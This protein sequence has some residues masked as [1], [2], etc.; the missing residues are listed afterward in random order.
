MR[1]S[2]F[3][4]IRSLVYERSRI[5]LGSDKRELVSARLGKRLRATN[6]ATVGE[7][8]LLLKSP[9]AEQ[10][11]ANLIDVISTNHT[12]FFREG[13][14]FDFLRSRAVPEMRERARAERWPQFNVWSAASSSGEETYSIAMT[15]SS[16]LT[17]WAW[18]IEGTDISHRIL[19][20]AQAAIYR[21]ETVNR[22]PP[23]LVRTYFQ[24]GFGPQEG[25][26]RV[27]SALRDHVSFRQLNLLEGE[28][29]FRDPFQVIFCR[30]VMIYFDTATQKRLVDETFAPSLDPEGYLFIGHSESLTGIHHRFTYVQPTVYEKR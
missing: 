30:N 23:E 8:C 14:H 15:L 17:D 24:R 4:F 13:A 12:F 19:E 10:E 2:E 26:Y 21:D 6:L 9:G 18:H 5:S 3:D 27:R 25:T 1:E 11:L 28:P 20:K 29:P 7:Y 16:C 22:L